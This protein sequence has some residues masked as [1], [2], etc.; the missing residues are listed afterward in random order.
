MTSS[1]P[2]AR[3]RI[4]LAVAP[5]VKV[6][7]SQPSPAPRPRSWRSRRRAASSTSVAMLCVGRCTCTLVSSALD[8]LSAASATGSVDPVTKPKYR[9]LR[10]WPGNAGAMVVRRCW[11][12]ASGPRGV[13]RDDGLEGGEEVVEGRDAR[14]VWSAE[15]VG[16]V[17][18]WVPGATA[19]SARVRV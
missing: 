9:L 16:S 8:R 14:A 6:L 7:P 5:V 1:R 11:S 3:P 15:E 10:L 2:H 12:V 18:A 4:L 17:R 13:G 19:A